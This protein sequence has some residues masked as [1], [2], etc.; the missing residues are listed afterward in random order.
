MLNTRRR[1]ESGTQWWLAS[2]VLL[3]VAL[4][5]LMFR[6]RYDRLP[7]LVFLRRY[8]AGG[9][10]WPGSVPATTDWLSSFREC[11][12]WSLTLMVVERG[13]LEAVCCAQ[14]TQPLNR[15]VWCF[16]L[17]WSRIPGHRG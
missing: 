15:R 4:T 9:T 12:R 11:G 10:A 6:M 8:V 2:P 14:W 1:G 17:A 13:L 3:L 16:L 7:P 5:C